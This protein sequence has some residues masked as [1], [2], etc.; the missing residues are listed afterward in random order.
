MGSK[1][2]MMKGSEIDGLSG[3]S[4][5]DEQDKLSDDGGL[6]VSPKGRDSDINLRQRDTISG[7]D[8]GYN[9]FNGDRIGGQ[10]Q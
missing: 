2:A 3:I 9:Y 1:F 5:K 10:V 4:K 7:R 6:I 8:A